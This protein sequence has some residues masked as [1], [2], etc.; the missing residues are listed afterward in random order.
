MS[1]EG[2]PGRFTVTVKK[3]PRYV[4]EKICNACGDC[5]AACPVTISDRFNRDLGTRKAIAKHYVQ[6]VPNL[7][8]ILKLGHAPCKTTCPANI[9]VQ[10]YIQLIKKKEY[11]KAVNLIRERN[12]L[13]AICGRVCTHPCETACT[14][15]KVDAPV[16]IRQLKR[17]ASD[18]EMEM[19]ESGQTRPS[20]GEDTVTGCP[21]SCHCRGRPFRPDC[22][23]GPR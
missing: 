4:D 15:G 19:V 22:G 2:D 16:A 17:F 21:E 3:S 13:S 8:G 12:P 18:K 1:I 10:G 11:I 23:P 20:S 9:N 7:P 5:T 6:A 14:R